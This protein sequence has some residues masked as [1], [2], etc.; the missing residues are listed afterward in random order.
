MA[1]AA[2]YSAPAEAET[3]RPVKVSAEAGRKCVRNI[4][5]YPI[6]SQ[7]WIALV[8]HLKQLSRLVELEGRIPANAKVAEAQ[9][10]NMES[11]GTLWDQ[12]AHEN[13]IR[14]LVEEAKVNLCLRMMNDYK[15]W[16]Y[17]AARKP[18]L[19]QAAATFGLSEPQVE[20]VC[21]QYEECLGLLLERAFEHV[22]TLQLI[23]IPLLVEHCGLILDY[24]SKA[25]PALI[26]ANTLMQ[27]FVVVMYFASLMKHSEALKNPELLPKVR[28]FRLVALVTHHILT[29]HKSYPPDMAMG[30]CSGLAA[31]CDNEDFMTEWEDFFEDPQARQS[32]LQVEE[33][34]VNPLLA[35]QPERKR[36]LRPLTDFFSKMRRAK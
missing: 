11:G 20:L 31:M 32:F 6:L 14:I 28:E 8:D 36:E 13:A 33:T 24:T 34:L 12:E 10:R 4:Y 2:K 29:H 3:E 35:E 21:S 7:E 17:K 9:G 1:S 23:D 27:E 16:A 5:Q 18:D 26:G 19:Q 22:E 25:E 15:T 30:L